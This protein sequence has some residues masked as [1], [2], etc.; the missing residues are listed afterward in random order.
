MPWLGYFDKILRS[1]IFVFLDNVQFKKNEFQNRNR[2]KTAQGWIWLTVPVMYKYPQRIEEVQLNNRVSW[3]K[4]HVRTVE[5][6]YQKT[7]YFH[8]LFPDIEKFYARDWE[9]LSEINRES[10]T[11]LM[12]MLG[13][14]KEIKVASSLGD[15]PE[16]PTERLVAICK[17]L[18]ADTY[19]SGTGGKGYLDHN[20]FH[21]AGITVVF[22]DFRHPIYPQ[23]Y[24]PFI[25]NLSILDL[26]FNCGLDALN[27]LR[28][29]GCD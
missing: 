18:G 22:Q 4:K 2:I 8:D 13:V 23:L 29:K 15:L 3:G 20:P 27:V 9:S 11:M 16:E 28:G 24:G 6:N 19:L 26:L 12:N 14:K 1:D 10:V 17:L 7:P 25:P 21:R 5:I